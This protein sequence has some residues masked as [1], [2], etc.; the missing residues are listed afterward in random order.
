MA[1]QRRG[2]TRI[3][4]ED[5]DSTPSLSP[6]KQESRARNVLLYQ[7]GRSAKSKDQCRKILAKRGIDT[8]IA[9]RILDRFEEAQIIDDVM[10]ARVFTNSRIKTKGLAKSAIARELREKGI[11]QPLIEDALVELDAESEQAR[12]TEL[13]VNRVRRMAGLERDVIQRRLSGFLARKGYSGSVVS[14]ATRAALAEAVKS[15][16]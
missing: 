6:E 12:A 10:F 7:L 3:G 9:E 16:A 13:A 2:R 11:S 15:E 4:N 5:S 8:E 14:S 1:L